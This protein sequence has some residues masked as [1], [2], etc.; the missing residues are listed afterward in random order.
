[1]PLK[2]KS[3]T[4]TRGSR[5]PG[6]ARTDGCAR[7]LPRK[8]PPTH[9]GEMLLDEF[10]TR[11]R[12]RNPNARSAGFSRFLPPERRHYEHARTVRA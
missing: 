12:A 9:P 1:M 11:A 3:R 5:R 6:P 2:S 4:T 7:R 8:R 10:L